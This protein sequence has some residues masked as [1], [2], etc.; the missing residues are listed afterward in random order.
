MTPEGSHPLL[1]RLPSLAWKGRSCHDPTGAPSHHP[2]PLP[3]LPLGAC[4]S[5]WEEGCGVRPQGGRSWS[6]DGAF[7]RALT[8]HSAR[9][10]F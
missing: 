1:P 5:G 4:C 8:F 3:L 9:S 2:K 7:S 10:G 6:G